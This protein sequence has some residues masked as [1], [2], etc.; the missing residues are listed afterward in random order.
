MDPMLAAVVAGNPAAS[1]PPVFAIEARKGGRGGGSSSC[2]G[3]SPPIPRRQNDPAG[4]IPSGLEKPGAPT[5][6]ISE[7]TR[8]ASEDEPYAGSSSGGVGM[9]A[10][11]PLLAVE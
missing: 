4:S 8:S 1:P 2:P 5:A 10:P 11:S 9:R 7:G 6:K 3:P